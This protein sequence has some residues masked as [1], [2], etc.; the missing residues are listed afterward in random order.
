MLI[1]FLLNIKY[2]FY[3]SLDINSILEQNGSKNTRSRRNESAP[4][5]PKRTYRLLKILFPECLKNLGFFFNNLWYS[6][7][8]I[9]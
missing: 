2:L 1:L 3:T 5:E 7:K 6:L 9:T 4:R 8:S